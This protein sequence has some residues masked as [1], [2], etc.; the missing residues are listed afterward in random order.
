MLTLTP[1]IQKGIIKATQ[2]HWDEKRKVGHLPYIIHPYSVAFIV[3]RYTDDED[4]IVGALLHDV[5]E[6]VNKDIYSDKEMIKDFG[7]HVYEIVKGV[8]E[9]K[10]ASMTKAEK[11]R[12][13]LSRK[14]KYLKRLK[15][16]SQGSLI[17]SAADKIH[18]LQSIINAYSKQGEIIFSK[19]NSSIDK[20]LWFYGEVLKIMKQKLKNNIVNEL[21][22]IYSQA[23]RIFK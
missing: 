23:L 19:F 1:K 16:S 21:E 10:D 2:L 6:D 12:T 17:V 22:T 15:N 13:W 3:S 11:K 4:T 9:I 14:R 7:N 20:S 8:S 18:N 5:L